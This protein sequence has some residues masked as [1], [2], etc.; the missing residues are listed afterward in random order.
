MSN[1]DVLGSHSNGSKSN[2]NCKTIS[3]GD[4]GKSMTADTGEWWNQSEPYGDGENHEENASVVE[5]IGN[6]TWTAVTLSLLTRWPHVQQLQ[7][8]LLYL[9]RCS[10]LQSLE[11]WEERSEML[12]A[13]HR[14]SL[15][16]PSKSD[17]LDDDGDYTSYLVLEPLQLSYHCV[18][19]LTM[20][21]LESPVP[22]WGVFTLDIVLAEQ[23]PTGLISPSHDISNKLSPSK[24]LSNERGFPGENFDTVVNFAQL[25]S[26]DLPICAYSL[27]CSLFRCLGSRG[28]LTVLSAA[29]A[30]S[31]ILFFSSDASLLPAV[32]ES[33]RILLY[34][35]KW[36]H[37]YL[38]VV[39]APLLDLVQAPVPFILGT[40]TK[41]M[42]LIPSECLSD[43]V[44]VDLDTG[45][46]DI[47]HTGTDEA[48]VPFPPK[49]ETWLLCALQ[50]IMITNAALID[51]SVSFSP[52][53]SSSDIKTKLNQIVEI[54]T[55]I[56]L[57]VFDV[58]ANLLRYVPGCIFS[59]NV[60][61]YEGPSHHVFNR[62]LFISE[63]VDEETCP[64]L[65]Q[66]TDTN[67]F[68]QF[69]ESLYSPSMGYF[70]K[71]LT[72]LPPPTKKSRSK[73]LSNVRR[74][75][76][77]GVSHIG[78]D[79]FPLVFEENDPKEIGNVV[80]HSIPDPV[81]KG[82]DR[83]NLIKLP[84]VSVTAESIIVTAPSSPAPIPDSSETRS[85][86]GSMR[87]M[88]VFPVASQQVN[89]PF[90]IDVADCN[91]PFSTYSNSPKGATSTVAFTSVM[92][93]M[94]PDWICASAAAL[95]EEEDMIQHCIG[96]ITLRVINTYVPLLVCE[97][98][99]Q[100]H[101]D[102][103]PIVGTLDYASYEGYQQGN[104]VSNRSQ[105]SNIESFPVLSLALFSSQSRA[106]STDLTSYKGCGTFSSDSQD[107][108]SGVKLPTKSPRLRALRNVSQLE[109]DLQV[110]EEILSTSAIT[111]MKE[112]RNSL[113]MRPLSS[114]DTSLA[115]SAK[116]RRTGSIIITSSSRASTCG[117]IKS[118]SPSY[119]AFLP[120]IG[121]ASALVSLSENELLMSSK[122][123]SESSSTPDSPSKSH[124]AIRPSTATSVGPG[125]W[126]ASLS[127]IPDTLPAT[128]PI[129]LR[130]HSYGRM[131]SSTFSMM[132]TSSNSD[133]NKQKPAR[134][135]HSAESVGV[136]LALTSAP[137]P[138]SKKRLNLQMLAA[139]KLLE[140][141]ENAYA[142]QVQI[143]DQQSSLLIESNKST[144]LSALSR[145]SSL[146]HHVSIDIPPALELELTPSS[147]QLCPPLKFDTDAFERSAGRIDEWTAGEL[148]IALKKPLKPLLK[149]LK[150]EV[151]AGTDPYSPWASSSPAHPLESTRSPFNVRSP[152][153]RG[154]HR[155]AV[156]I[157]GAVSDY[158]QFAFSG[159][160]MSPR[161]VD[162]L[163]RRCAT[164]LADH[165]NRMRLVQLLRQTN[166]TVSS[167]SSLPRSAA[168]MHGTALPDS[169]FS[170]PPPPPPA[171]QRLESQ[172][173]PL[174]TSTFELL[175][176]L[177]SLAVDA[178][179]CD[180]DYLAA[181]GLLGV[182]GLY[183]QIQQKEAQ[184]PLS[185]GDR[186]LHP[187]RE[188][189]PVIDGT[190]ETEFLSERVCQHPIFQNP[191]LWLSVLKDR[192]STSTSP[193]TPSDNRR[194]YYSPEKMKETGTNLKE[195]DAL[196]SEAYAL[197]FIINRLGV[198]FE[199]AAAFNKMVSSEYGLAK[200]QYRQIQ[201]Y[202]D[203]LYSR[204]HAPSDDPSLFSPPRLR[205]DQT[206]SWDPSPLKEDGMSVGSSPYPLSNR[207]KRLSFRSA[208]S[209]RRGSDTKE[210]QNQNQNHNQ[211][212]PGYTPLGLY[213]QRANDKTST[214][215]ADLTLL[216]PILLAPYQEESNHGP[217]SVSIPLKSATR[218]PSF[219]PLSLMAMTRSPPFQSPLPNSVGSKG[220]GYVAHTDRIPINAGPGTWI[221]RR[222]SWKSGTERDSSSLEGSKTVPRSSLIA[223]KFKSYF[224][225][226]VVKKEY[227]DNN[228]EVESMQ[229]HSVHSTTSI[230]TIAKIDCKMN[231]SLS[232]LKQWSPMSNEKDQRLGEVGIN[233][234]SK[235]DMTQYCPVNLEVS[236]EG[237][238]SIALGFIVFSPFRVSSVLLSHDQFQITAHK[239]FEL[240]ST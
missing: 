41:W 15:R 202:T 205:N 240:I 26:E 64:F 47:M 81:I 46:I 199:R 96:T 102:Q 34:P 63:C 203:K 8:C 136:T 126:P 14:T 221:G 194:T 2:R 157:G 128:A 50:D 104:I 71:A 130:S 153:R 111:M 42:D 107:F 201:Q 196:F 179:V 60:G 198:N 3:R 108:K 4:S 32:C 30:E 49:I 101:V 219:S 237:N 16:L 85:N 171:E 213:R 119:M 67:A 82:G 72:A 158:L 87:G 88:L 86:S 223:R 18:E 56:Q 164:A 110:A 206:S 220:F 1:I 156:G 226:R 109:K 118:S 127:P 176:R 28:V 106:Q 53:K 68:E 227:S 165:S 225:K 172:L 200:G 105:L 233:G 166:K 145:S 180:R 113:P 159:V 207:E 25:P 58:M 37:V 175:S 235:K 142:D 167:A 150:R 195:F 43:V 144:E 149:M 83:L 162:H 232:S 77:R 75:G 229:H 193:R 143:Q 160:S 218:K 178:C 138:C 10:I 121:K 48:I 103:H 168:A 116:R 134:R 155:V 217:T 45:A 12:L 228:T 163:E 173:F 23:P 152:I 122:A 89:R 186:S 132:P 137:F 91:S 59:L 36:A 79:V 99:R 27:S 95:D 57:I 6:C 133:V 135:R 74:Q 210:N 70:L 191:Q 94:F 98:G 78:R 117:S 93:T 17:D 177:Y 212:L 139:A 236:G 188:I 215:F 24:K 5:G 92:A 184:R 147:C 112:K 38:P 19:L 29:L 238:K 33:L 31:R 39:P 114:K 124:A 161:Q 234:E 148:A 208:S 129:L 7:R 174:H 123:D 9:Y 69:T 20:L 182:G 140:Q 187:E 239:F 52:S 151:E 197:L 214:S 76:R 80:C 35:L 84:T 21:C 22:V 62:P 40:L 141:Q 181:Y 222:S 73:G 11:L 44:L 125:G 185:F 190:E 170:P 231:P 54:D 183:Y 13:E 51:S 100:R 192:L 115:A 97:R 55:A 66:L 216:L 211:M 146:S 204:S 65:L 169:H 209:V 224:G 131:R 189:S 61:V 90:S 230:A 154:S 120:L